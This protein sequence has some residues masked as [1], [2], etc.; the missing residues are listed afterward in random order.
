MNF[1][2]L[3]VSLFPF[4]GK[5]KLSLGNRHSMACSVLTLS[6]L[7]FLSSRLTEVWTTN[8]C[9]VS[10]YLSY[11]LIRM[12]QL[13]FPSYPRRTWTTS[14][15]QVS[16]FQHQT[17]TILP[18]E[19]HQLSTTPSLLRSETNHT[20]IGLT[21]SYPTMICPSHLQLRT[22]VTSTCHVWTIVRGNFGLKALHRQTFPKEF[23]V[24][25]HFIYIWRNF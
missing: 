12:K 18:R 5:F 19:L 20:L 13:K 22:V 3:Q 6:G 15:Q 4:L 10:R 1:D 7:M 23:A 11:F 8:R 16:T 14:I 24:Y 17:Y 21:S 9:Q 2:D 25:A